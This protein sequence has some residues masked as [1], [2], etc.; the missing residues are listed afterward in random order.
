MTGRTDSVS[1]TDQIQSKSRDPNSQWEFCRKYGTLHVYLLVVYISVY[2]C[3]TVLFRVIHAS[4]LSSI[5]LYSSLSS[6]PT[7][8]PSPQAPTTP[9]AGC[10]TC[11][12][13]RSSAS[14][15][16]TTSSVASPPWLSRAPA[17]CCWLVTMTLTATS[18]TP[19]RETEQVG[20]AGNSCVSVWCQRVG[21]RRWSRS[22][23]YIHY[24]GLFIF[25][26]SLL[27]SF[28][29]RGMIVAVLCALYTL[30]HRLKRLYKD[31]GCLVWR[32]GTISYDCK[33]KLTLIQLKTK[34][35]SI[36]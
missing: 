18:G 13:T 15:A 30:H 4:C 24:G 12:Q 9:P 2:I 6:F 32:K 14:T 34:W 19:W 21:L 28:C 16:M 35:K 11:V 8:A 3:L 25:F 20:G 7:A 29:H 36:F 22:E 1:Q 27:C 5:F 17:V 26:C 10:L 31:T 33:E 23:E